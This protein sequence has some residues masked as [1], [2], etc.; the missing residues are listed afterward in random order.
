MPTAASGA[1]RKVGGFGIGGTFSFQASKTM[2]AGEGGMIISDDDDF[3]RLARSTHDCGRLPGE[4]FYDHFIY[5]SK[6]S[7]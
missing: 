6:L 7:A 2:T 5:G 3:E 4:W 1:G